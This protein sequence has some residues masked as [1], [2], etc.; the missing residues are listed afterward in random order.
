M[1][2]SSVLPVLGHVKSGRARPIAIASTRRFAGLPDVPTFK[3]SG[4]P[5]EMG[6]WFGVLVPAGTPKPIVGQLHAEIARIVALPEVR[7][8]IAA[9]GGEPIGNTP[10]AFAAF[11]RKESARWAKVIAAAKITPE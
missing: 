5:F 8:R 2:F 9:E 3:E 4:V 10:E 7:E 1:L 6:T 11:L